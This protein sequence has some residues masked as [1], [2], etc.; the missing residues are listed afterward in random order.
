M[1]IGPISVLLSARRVANFARD[2]GVLD[3]AEGRRAR[4][5]HMG[6]VVAD[7]VLQTGLNY[8][9]VVRPRVEAILLNHPQLRGV[10]A[11]IRLVDD[12]REVSTFLR[13]RHPEK[14]IRFE[15]LVRFLSSW[16]IESCEDLRANLL[17]LE[18]RQAVGAVHGVGPKTIDYLSCLVGNDCVAVD[19]HV[20]AYASRAGVDSQD[21]DFLRDVF[22]GAADLLNVSRDAFDAWIWR[23]GS[24]RSAKDGVR[25]RAF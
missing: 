16:S 6:A 19:R 5:C 17:L 15:L 22:C 10:S 9:S 14:L 21:Y 3:A 11:L 8:A 25:R 4:H 2:D 1:T 13:W 7:A 23:Q 12:R 20:R 24:L 18:F